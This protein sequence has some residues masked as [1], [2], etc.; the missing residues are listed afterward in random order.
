LNPWGVFDE[1]LRIESLY[2]PLLI[3]IRPYYNTMHLPR[4]NYS[5][6]VKN[7]S[8][9]SSTIKMDIEQK[10]VSKKLMKLPNFG[11]SHFSCFNQENG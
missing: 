3:I 4:E 2:H 1:N 9:N 7:V 5:S 10:N 11:Y 8:K 6:T